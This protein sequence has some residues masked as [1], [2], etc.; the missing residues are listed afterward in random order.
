MEWLAFEPEHAMLFAVN[1]TG[2]RPRR[3]PE[4][5]ESWETREYVSRLLARQHEEREY[6]QRRD[7]G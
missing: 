4:E 1:V 7:G 2:G 5:G 6:V 3:P